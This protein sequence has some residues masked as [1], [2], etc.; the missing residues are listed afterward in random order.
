M[1]IRVRFEKENGQWGKL[2]LL[3][4]L[5]LAAVAGV[6]PGRAA[7]SVTLAWNP[8][9][10]TNLAGYKLY[11][12]TS[13]RNYSGYVPVGSATTTGTV[14]N[15]Q[16]GL[17]YFFAVTAYC[18]DGMESDYSGEV[19]Y[20]VIGT[21]T[22]LPPVAIGGAVGGWEDQAF[23]IVLSGSDPDGDPLTYTLT[24]PPAN[25][26]LSGTA[27]NLT[28]TPAAGFNG[29][30]SLAFRVSDGKVNSAAATISI[31][32]S[33]VNDAPT[34]ASINGVT[35]NEDAAAQTVNLS[36]IGTGAANESQTLAVTATSSNPSLIPNPA[37]TYT[38][39]NATGSLGFTPAANGNGTATITV[40]VNDGQAQNNTV[41]RT[42]TVTVNA[43]NDA[44][45]L[46]ALS[47]LSLPPGAGAQTVNLSG[48]GTGA[49]NESQTL[50]VTATSSN[51]SVV[52]NPS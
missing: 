28:Y 27:P 7:Q 31:T 50:T 25:G 17:T 37:V 8:N 12:G 3:L 42:F 23:S 51:P 11:Y 2:R 34:L 30:D 35:I 10:E 40:M 36:G 4:W 44:P 6:L 14:P 52:P 38:S 43:V 1:S 15:L 47:N 22:N 20:Q 48:I 39:P 18:T 21:Q 26:T 5:F 13:S 16:D 24:S 33:A 46:N 41:T 9:S 19:S 32:V 29:T 49:A 45:T